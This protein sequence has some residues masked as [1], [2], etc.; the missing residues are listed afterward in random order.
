M[1]TN[2]TEGRDLRENRELTTEATCENREYVRTERKC[3]NMQQQIERENRD[4]IQNSE[5]M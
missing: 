5:N 2:R 3:E 4:K 1:R